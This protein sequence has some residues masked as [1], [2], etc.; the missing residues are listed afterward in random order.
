[1]GWGW[2]ED[3]RRNR[4]EKTA[5]QEEMETKVSEEDKERNERG[6]GLFPSPSSLPPSLSAVTLTG[7]VIGRG[8]LSFFFSF[9]LSSPWLCSSAGALGPGNSWWQ[10][11]SCLSFCSRL[12]P[13]DS[14]IGVCLLKCAFKERQAAEKVHLF[15]CL[16]FSAQSSWPPDVCTGWTMVVIV[17]SGTYKVRRCGARGSFSKTKKV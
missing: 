8:P 6:E 13:P 15:V 5:K 7:P 9:A 14:R 3:N 10:D 4:K 12:P 16:L 2:G 17:L 1:M 11:S